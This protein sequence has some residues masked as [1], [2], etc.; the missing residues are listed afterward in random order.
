MKR[1]ARLLRD[2]SRKEARATKHMAAVMC[3]TVGARCRLGL[4]D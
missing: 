3:S 1:E 4:G 2:G